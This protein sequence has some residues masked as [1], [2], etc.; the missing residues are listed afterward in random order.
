MNSLG[1]ELGYGLGSA[2]GTL[3]GVGLEWLGLE[4]V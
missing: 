1:A 3:L 2:L 4:L